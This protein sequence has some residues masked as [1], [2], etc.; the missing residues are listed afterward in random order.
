MFTD[1]LTPQPG[2][3]FCSNNW[4]L[5]YIYFKRFAYGEISRSQSIGEFVLG[6][7]IKKA[8]FL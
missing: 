5:Y 2:L 7:Q 4:S 3:L 8:S 1:R 6:T